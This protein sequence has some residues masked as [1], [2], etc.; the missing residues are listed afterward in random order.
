MTDNNKTIT[1]ELDF[2]KLHD[3]L[4]RAMDVRSGIGQPVLEKWLLAALSSKSAEFEAKFSEIIT[5]VINDPKIKTLAA[6][7]FLSAYHDNIKKIA[8]TAAM[9]AVALA[10]DE[11]QQKKDG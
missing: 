3:I 6:S 8:K 5:E 10:L 4:V 11:Q 7:A 9:Q 1:V 2:G